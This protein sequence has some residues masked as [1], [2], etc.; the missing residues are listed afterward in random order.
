[1]RKVILF[2]GSFDPIHFGHIEM[3]RRAKEQ[4]GADEVVFIL[5]KKPRWKSP[6]ADVRLRLDMLRLG[7]QNIN[8]FSISLFEVDS[9]SPINYTI[10]T[11]KH[12]TESYKT[13]ELYYL[14]GF[15]QVAK[16]PE[17]KNPDEIASLAHVI[18]YGRTDYPLDQA[19]VDTYKM[20]LVTGPMLDVSSTAIRELRSL[21][22]P[23]SVISY[24]VD[25]D[26]YFMKKLHS[27]I[28]NRRL[29][30]SVS[31]AKLA[32]SIAENNGLEPQKAFLAGLLHDIGKDNL[33]G[34]DMKSK[35]REICSIKYEDLPKFAYHQFS[36]S[37]IAACEFGVTD[38]EVIDAIR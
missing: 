2:G 28:N 21:N 26:L 6:S 18:A 4:V 17:W 8:G 10:D 27:F 9:E 22:T 37:L 24:I 19:I 16:F 12:F 14:I 25:Q 31:V 32:Y 1:M 34:E 11:I 30:H 7:I 20:T 15:D 36:G 13:A 3:A 5:A 29:D 23:Y 35:I 33:H 38:P